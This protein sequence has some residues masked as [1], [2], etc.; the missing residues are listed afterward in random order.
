M[1]CVRWFSSARNTF[2]PGG[3]RVAPLKGIRVLELTLNISGALSGQILAALGAE[4]VKVERPGTGD[5]CRSFGP[6]FV[7]GASVMYNGMNRGKSSVTL[8]LKTPQAIEWL[9]AH[10]VDCDVLIENMRPGTLG[11]L[12]IGIPLLRERYPRLICV[13]LSAFGA[14]GPLAAKPGYEEVVQAFSGLFSVNGA[15][16]SPP[17]RVGTQI[18]D[19]GTGVW[20]AVGCLAGL[21]QRQQTG[22]GCTVEGS[23]LETAIS[24]L[25]L[26]LGSFSL[27]G[28]PPVRS[29]S[30]GA[31]VAPYRCFSAADGEIVIAAI[32]DRLFVQLCDA[33]GHPEWAGDARFREAAARAV[34]REAI[35]A[36]IEP[37]IA[38]NSR[39]HWRTLLEK[40]GVPCSP[41]NTLAEV[42]AE[43][44][45]RQLDLFDAMPGS[46]GVLAR[47]PI[48]IDG[49]RGMP[50]APAP[51]LGNANA[52]LL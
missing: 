27:T 17:A 21:M 8:D 19:M 26:P 46:E 37:V 44:H 10:L 28:C 48:S 51:T 18:L 36:L 35:H 2:F 3:N 11:A 25:T 30:G 45:V 1:S 42:L 5:D 31:S 38:M 41:V 15:E 49:S 23:L 9:H 24:W 50:L 33:L 29:R 43:P 22:R 34:N 47:M 20:G 14:Q 7:R 32:N 6:P 39:A 52:S 40:A 16:G 13:S 12:G 4:V